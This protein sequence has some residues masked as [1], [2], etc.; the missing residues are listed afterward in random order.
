M[1]FLV[2]LILSRAALMEATP[3]TRSWY[4]INEQL[5]ACMGSDPDATKSNEFATNA[6]VLFRLFMSLWF[7]CQASPC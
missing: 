5:F 7:P 1:P 4:P 6:K 3:T 2:F